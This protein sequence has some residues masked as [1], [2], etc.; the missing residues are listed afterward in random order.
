MD[1][2]QR[3]STNNNTDSNEKE[4]TSVRWEPDSFDALWD[5]VISQ[6]LEDRHAF[7]EHTNPSTFP[8]DLEYA[9]AITDISRLYP[10]MESQ[11][12]AMKAGRGERLSLDEQHKMAFFRLGELN[13]QTDANGLAMNTDVFEAE[14]ERLIERGWNEPVWQYYGPMLLALERAQRMTGEDRIRGGNCPVYACGY[15]W[16]QSNAI[17]ARRLQ[18]RLQA[19]WE[20]EERITGSTP[21]GFILVTHSMGGL[22]ARSYLEQFAEEA[23][24]QIEAVVHISQPAHGAPIL[25]RRLKTGASPARGDGTMTGVLDNLFDFI[26]RGES[27]RRTALML[28]GFPSV[29]ELLPSSA[30]RL[31]DRQRDDPL[32]GPHHS[33]LSWDRGLLPTDPPDPAVL[34]VPGDSAAPPD[35]TFA[36]PPERHPDVMYVT[37]DPDRASAEIPNASPADGQG[38]PLADADPHLASLFDDAYADPTGLVGIVPHDLDEPYASQLREFLRRAKAFQETIDGVVH[39]TTYWGGSTGHD[40]DTAITYLDPSFLEREAAALADMQSVDMMLMQHFRDPKVDIAQGETEG[41]EG[42]GTDAVMLHAQPEDG[43]GTVPLAS[44]LGPETE[45]SPNVRIVEGPGHAETCASEPLQQQ[46]LDWIQ[47]VIF[48]RCPL[49]PSGWSPQK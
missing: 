25:Y 32:P 10:T 13:V 26:D 42:A 1:S 21:D 14:R 48:E 31:L 47:S 17:S 33:W 46:T 2:S 15:D 45:E 41:N 30:F 37:P 29:L 23:E 39:P 43:D 12:L 3:A 9:D 20:R 18:Q 38:T 28:S 44:Q 27:P 7:L 34:T 40:T 11:Q 49:V 16:R 19:I 6:K 22:V 35:A 8:Q 36:V 4:A 24:V 5:D